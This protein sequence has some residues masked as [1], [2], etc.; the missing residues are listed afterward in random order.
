MA[1]A[2][3]PSRISLPSKNEQWNSL[4]E[5]LSEKFPH[6][7]EAIWIARFNDGKMHWLEGEVVDLSTPFIA[8]KTL[9]YYREVEQEPS[10]PFQHLVLFQNEH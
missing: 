10:I 2:K 8:N 1:I 6:I 9:C 4:L 3:R 7:S 5:Y